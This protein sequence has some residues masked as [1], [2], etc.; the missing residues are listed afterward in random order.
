MPGSVLSSL[1]ALVHLIHTSVLGS[2]C[3]DHFHFVYEE[4][5]PLRGKVTCPKTLS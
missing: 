1:F 2:D 4:P 3:C 5:E